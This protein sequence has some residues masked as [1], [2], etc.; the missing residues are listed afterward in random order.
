MDFQPALE[1]CKPHLKEIAK[2]L[3]LKYA[4]GALQEAVA[5]SETKIDDMALEALLP[6]FQAAFVSMIEKA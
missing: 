2:I 6:G 1:E 4:V 3:V 5:K